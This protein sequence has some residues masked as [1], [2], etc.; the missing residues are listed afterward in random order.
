[1]DKSTVF[2]KIE[3]EN[4]AFQCPDYKPELS[5]ILKDLAERVRVDDLGFPRLIKDING[6]TVGNA[7]IFTPAKRIL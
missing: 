1:M 7:Y 3:I 6:N 4:A 5:R 2:I